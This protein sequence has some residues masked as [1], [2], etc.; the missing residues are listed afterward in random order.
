MTSSTLNQKNMIQ[1]YANYVGADDLS[2]KTVQKGVKIYNKL[3]KDQSLVNAG[4]SLKADSKMQNAILSILTGMSAETGANNGSFNNLTLEQVKLLSRVIEKETGGN[5]YINRA[6]EKP[7]LVT[8]A[9]N[10]ARFIKTIKRYPNYFKFLNQ[11]ADKKRYS[12]SQFRT[13]IDSSSSKWYVHFRERNQNKESLI[14]YGLLSGYPLQ[15]TIS[16]FDMESLP[17]HVVQLPFGGYIG[18]NKEIDNI[19]AEKRFIMVKDAYN[20]FSDT[21]N[22]DQKTQLHDL[23]PQNRNLL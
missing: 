8:Y 13:F 4:I 12:L 5:C 22:K 17:H 15:A 3:L 1:E 9:I 11:F 23:Q 7:Y 21:W 2:P 10:T 6:Q 14:R 16:F 20:S 19:F 18:F